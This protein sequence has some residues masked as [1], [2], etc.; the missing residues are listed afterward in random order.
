MVL[1]DTE[2]IVSIPFI[3]GMAFIIGLAIREL[4]QKKKGRNRK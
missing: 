3:V 2:Y 1:L 4:M